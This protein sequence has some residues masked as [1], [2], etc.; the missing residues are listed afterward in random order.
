LKNLG[1]PAQVDLAYYKD[2]ARKSQIPA[3]AGGGEI[4]RAT[5][6]QLAIARL[7]AADTSG[8]R[9]TEPKYACSETTTFTS[10]TSV[11]YSEGG[12]TARTV[13]L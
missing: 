8:Q 10:S 11:I 4:R 3:S 5:G 6:A 7:L 1:T 13:H 9:T 12:M 2:L